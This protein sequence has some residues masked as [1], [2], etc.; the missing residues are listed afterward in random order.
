MRSTSSRPMRFCEPHPELSH[1]RWIKCAKSSCK[2]NCNERPLGWEKSW[3][4]QRSLTSSSSRRHA[5]RMSWRRRNA[6]LLWT[7][8]R[9][10]NSI[11]EESSPLMSLI[12]KTK[13]QNFQ[14]KGDIVLEKNCCVK[15]SKKN[16]RK[17]ILRNKTER[18]CR[19]RY[20]SESDKK[21]DFY[22]G[23]INGHLPILYYP[24]MWSHFASSREL[25]P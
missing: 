23:R 21:R 4:S 20:F 17:K 22:S 6:S 24:V 18:E 10:F 25:Y 3:M 8:W 14:K 12:W 1:W 16:R 19:I 15:D 7:W 2:S 5:V 11:A 9:R 13:T